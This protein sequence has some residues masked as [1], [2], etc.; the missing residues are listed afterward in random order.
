MFPVNKNFIQI[1]YHSLVVKIGA[2][3]F[4]DKKTFNSIK[5]DADSFDIIRTLESENKRRG[6]NVVEFTN[7][8]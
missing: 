5:H 8:K 4:V 1:I 2:G 7:E 6:K 3:F